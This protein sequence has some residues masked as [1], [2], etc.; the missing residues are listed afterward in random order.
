MFSKL[1]HTTDV[2]FF[3]HLVLQGSIPLCFHDILLMSNSKPQV[4]QPIKQLHDIAMKE[5]LKLASEILIHASHCKVSW[6]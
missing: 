3:E 2:S 1:F 6:S 4:Q 5:K